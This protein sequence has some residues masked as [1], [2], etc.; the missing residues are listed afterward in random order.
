M[1][2]INLHVMHSWGGGLER[3][4]QDYCRADQ[5]DTNF[6]LKSIGE[7]GIPARKI[8]LYQHIDDIVPI[9]I[10][11]LDK[12]ILATAVTHLEYRYIL[13]EIID[14]FHINNL[15]ISSFIGH[16]LEL[17]Q[18]DIRTMIICHDFYPFCP[19]IIAYFKKNCQECNFSH[20]KKCFT[21]NTTQFFPFTSA[22]EWMEIR[23]V[24]IDTVRR[25][26]IQL[27]VPSPFMKNR[28]ISLEPKLAEVP[29]LVISHGILPL[30]LSKPPTIAKVNSLKR[31]PRILILGD[32]PDH[33]GFELFSQICDQL[34]KTV[35]FYLLG[36]GDHGKLFEHKSHVKII[37]RYQRS[38]LPTMVDELDIDLGLLLS[39]STETFSYT[40]SE[41]M[42]MGIPT[43]ATNLGSFTDRI[44]DGA[45]GFL[46]NPIAA[47]VINKINFLVKHDHVLEAVRNNL[48]DLKY[49][50][51]QSMVLEYQEQLDIS[52]PKIK[53]INITSLDQTLPNSLNH[54][55]LSQVL[56]LF[57]QELIDLKYSQAKLSNR[58]E[59]QEFYPNW[60]ISKKI[61]TPFS[62]RF[63]ILK[64]IKYLFPSQ[65]NSLRIFAMRIKSS[66]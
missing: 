28:L 10:W 21:D 11:H 43:L 25:K 52:L 64:Y 45:N 6:V 20:L 42:L 34:G 15:L 30:I 63:K 57:Q 4:V 56:Q 19:V 65:W 23:N 48:L 9:R 5:R 17:L 3:W 22:I 38:E 39:I 59:Q 1:N 55:G 26:Q 44:E 31:K 58:L 60:N 49:K 16:A 50:S 35:D 32:L 37:P 33:K 61:H 13:Q 54:D 51:T 18:I 27:I 12:P 46:V 7:S 66:R 24:F 41:L 47:D 40:L 14:V 62:Q 53:Q 29:I 36:C 8:C 2:M